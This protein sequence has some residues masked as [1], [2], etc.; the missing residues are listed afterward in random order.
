MMD[1]VRTA[2]LVVHDAA[3]LIAVFYSPILW[4]TFNTGGQAFAAAA[5]GVAALAALISRWT[6]GRAL[7]RIPNAIHMPAIAFLAITAITSVSSVSV[8]A[9]T[10]ELCRLTTG[11]LLFLLVANRALLPAPPSNAVAALFTCSVV[12]AAFIPVPGEP[13]MALKLFS[14]IAIGLTCAVIVVQKDKGGGANWWIGALVLSAAFVVALYGLRE[15]VVVWKVLDN[16]TWQIFSTFFNPNPLGGFFAMVF[17]L[18][19]SA[20]LVGRAT[21]QKML[22]G[23]CALLV[24]AAILPTYSKGAMLAFLISAALYPVLLGWRSKRVRRSVEAGMAALA[25]LALLLGAAGWRS[26]S[27]RQRLGGALHAQSASNMFRILTWKGTVDLAAAHPWLGIGPGAFKYVYPKYATAHYVEAAHQNYLQVAAEQGIPGGAIFLWLVVAVLLTGKRALTR[28]SDFRGRALAVGGVC[29]IV[30]LLVHSFLDYDW[31]IGAIGLVFWL[32]AGMLARQAHGF[33]VVALER[34]AEPPRGRRRRPRTSSPAVPAD[35]AARE[36]PWPRGTAGQVGGL[37]IAVLA[38]SLCVWVPAR[39][40]LAQQAI[41][42]GDAAAMSRQAQLALQLYQKATQYDPQWAEAWERYGLLKGIMGDLGEG[43]R[44]VKRAMTLEPTSFRRRV[45]LGRLYE[46]GGRTDQA[47]TL[48]HEGLERFPNHTRTLRRLA[49]AYQSIGDTESAL[50]I[51]QRMLEIEDSP[52][53]S[54]RA[55][56]GVDVDVEYAYAHYQ[57]GRAA[58]RDSGSPAAALPEFDQALRVVRAYF[59][60]A[61]QTDRMFLTLGKPREYR[62]EDMHMLEAKVRWRMAE[63]YEL[64]GETARVAEERRQAVSIW[65]EVRRAAAMEDGN[66]AG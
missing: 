58:L 18:A 34:P 57:L 28:A 4:G 21:W 9:S 53:N 47:I 44:A 41:T 51:Y 55:L 46:E 16:P 43:E 48:Y 5:V 39:N 25:I 11:V 12:V 52:Y 6:Q 61:E 38:M 35:H 23:F 62:A 20:A 45:S 30:A 36:L 66:E 10:I 24:T 37:A 8:H 31:Y 50:S 22:W 27:V 60:K 3:L 63:A 13:G 49:E 42:K 15:K 32:V 29:S 65:P 33:P 54:Y 14:V 56:A 40:A 1:R 19:L 17:P 59:D 7:A 64:A 26:Q 2:A